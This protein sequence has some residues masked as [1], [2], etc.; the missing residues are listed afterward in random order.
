MP[1]VTEETEY[2]LIIKTNYYKNNVENTQRYTF[3]LIVAPAVVNTTVNMTINTTEIN[4]VM[5]RGADSFN[6]AYD[7]LEKRLSM[8]EIKSKFCGNCGGHIPCG[9][10]DESP[11]A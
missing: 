9:C 1:N 10:G 7:M 11:Q 5:V 2:A 3:P 4:T 8:K 6:I